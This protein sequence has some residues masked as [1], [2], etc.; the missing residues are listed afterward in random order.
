MILIYKIDNFCV[1]RFVMD[2]KEKFLPKKNKVFLCNDLAF[3][4]FKQK[5]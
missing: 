3:V 1:I 5:D 2:I 4:I